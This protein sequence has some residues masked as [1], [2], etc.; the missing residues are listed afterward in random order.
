MGPLQEQKEKLMQQVEVE[1]SEG[2]DDNR[3]TKG[4]KWDPEGKYEIDYY[5]LQGFRGRK[6][7][8]EPKEK[9]LTSTKYDVHKFT[10]EMTLGKCTLEMFLR[11]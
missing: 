8:K 1:E 9:D 4:W 5:A 3:R 11:M 7:V 6:L 10:L 2:V